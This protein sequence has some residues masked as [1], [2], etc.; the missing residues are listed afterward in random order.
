LNPK[1]SISGC[2]GITMSVNSISDTIN[3]FLSCWIIK[4]NN[5]YFVTTSLDDLI[6]G[7]WGANLS[8]KSNAGKSY[9]VFGKQDTDAVELSAIAAGKGASFADS[10][11]ITKPLWAPINVTPFWT[12]NSALAAV[13]ALLWA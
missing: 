1:L 5:Y 8:G 3:S 10:P 11:L 13:L 4:A 2:I 6:I 12:Q 7:A 9:V